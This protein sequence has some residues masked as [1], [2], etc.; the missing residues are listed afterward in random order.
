MTVL[1]S[2]GSFVFFRITLSLVL[3]PR[4]GTQSTGKNPDSEVGI[5]TLLVRL[6]CTRFVFYD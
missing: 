6:V 5:A 1:Y 2:D 3:K 4:P